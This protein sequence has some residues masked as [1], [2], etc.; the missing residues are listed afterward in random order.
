MLSKMLQIDVALNCNVLYVWQYIWMK[1][2]KFFQYY[3]VGLT[4]NY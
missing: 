2:C 4:H 3:L 1:K